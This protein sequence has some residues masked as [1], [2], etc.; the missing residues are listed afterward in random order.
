MA[1]K[2]GHGNLGNGLG[3]RRRLILL[4]PSSAL[5]DRVPSLGIVFA[6]MIPSKDAISDI[7][8]SFLLLTVSAPPETGPKSAGCQ[9]WLHTPRTRVDYPSH[10]LRNLFFYGAL[11]IT[12]V[13]KTLNEA[14]CHGRRSVAIFLHIII[15]Q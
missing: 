1:E 15:V 3:Q 5:R 8:Y 14:C 2:D 4:E 12:L 6:R 13:R 10:I 9:D 7:I 11:R